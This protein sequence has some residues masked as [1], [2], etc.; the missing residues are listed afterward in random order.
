M[1]DDHGKSNARLAQ[2]AKQAVIPLPNELA[3][4]QQDAKRMLSA[5]VQGQF[6]A[7]YMRLQVLDHQKTVQLLLWVIASGENADLQHFASDMLPAVL[8][9]LHVA[10]SLV[11]QLTGAA[12][13]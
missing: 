10:Q 6:E 7:E 1:I 8:H 5:L 2:L 13:P 3:S 11:S 4:D 9:H 12:A